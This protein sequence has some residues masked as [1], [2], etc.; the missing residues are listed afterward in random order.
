MLVRWRDRQ[1]GALDELTPLIYDELRRLAHRRLSGERRD[2]P[3]QTTELVHEAFVR[4]IDSKVSWADRVHFFAVAATVMRRVLVDHAR[5]QRSKKRGAGVVAL[6]LDE[7]LHGGVGL[8]TDL[9]DLDQALDRLAGL[10]ERK[11]RA[12][13]LHFFAGLTYE[14]VATAL[15]ISTA[16]V[17]RELTFSRAWLRRALT[18]RPT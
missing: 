3:L 5:A 6:P 14:E 12:V 7:A 15:S 8:D 1:Q 18:G 10:D 13:E 2:H 4:L 17:H 16:T 11:A 9:L